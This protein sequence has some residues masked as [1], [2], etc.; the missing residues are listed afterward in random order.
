V[1][2]YARFASINDVYVL[3]F[4]NFSG[5][6]KSSVMASMALLRCKQYFDGAEADGFA[7]GDCRFHQHG[8]YEG[9]NVK[10]GH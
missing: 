8:F 6:F 2:A 3:A 7:V 9:C 1:G 5:H 4:S 10:G